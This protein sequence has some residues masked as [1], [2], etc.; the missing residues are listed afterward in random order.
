MG[1][2]DSRRMMPAVFPPEGVAA[3]EEEGLDRPL[4]LEPPRLE[5]VGVTSMTQGSS[6]RTS[7]ADARPPLPRPKTRAEQNGVPPPPPPGRTP[8]PILKAREEEKAEDM[9]CTATMA[10]MVKFHN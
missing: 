9:D 8:R 2:A 10:A 7:E 6:L 4:L 3:E 1:P 5:F